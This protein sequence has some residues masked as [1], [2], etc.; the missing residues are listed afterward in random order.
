MGGIPAIAILIT[1]ITGA[2]I[3]FTMLVFSWVRFEKQ[4]KKLLKFMEEL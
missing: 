3:C 2:V 1:G 4:K